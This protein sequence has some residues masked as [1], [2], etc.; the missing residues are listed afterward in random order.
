MI[1]TVKK[2]TNFSVKCERGNSYRT[3][4]PQR[5]AN[6]CHILQ[7]LIFMMIGHMGDTHTGRNTSAVNDMLRF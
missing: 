6:S 5:L 1:N 4:L 3:R 7:S 2:I